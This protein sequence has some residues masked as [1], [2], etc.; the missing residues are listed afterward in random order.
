MKAH[1]QDTVSRPCR[2]TYTETETVTR[3][4]EETRTE[5]FTKTKTFT[6]IA[7]NEKRRA[8]EMAHGLLRGSPEQPSAPR[9]STR[10]LVDTDRLT[11]I[12]AFV[13]AVF[14]ELVCPRQM[15]KPAFATL[16]PQLIRGR[17][18]GGRVVQAANHD[19]GFVISEMNDTRA[20]LGAK[21]PAVEGGKFPRAL[22]GI[23]GPY[24]EEGEG[25]SA[26]LAAIGAVAD[27][28]SQRQAGHGVPDG[29]TEAAANSLK[30]AHRPTSHADGSNAFTFDM[31]CIT[32][33]VRPTLP[34]VPSRLWRIAERRPW[35]TGPAQFRQRGTPRRY[36]S[37]IARVISA[38]GLRL[39]SAWRWPADSFLRGDIGGGDDARRRLDLQ[40][41]QLGEQAAQKFHGETPR[42]CR[43]NSDSRH[44]FRVSLIPAW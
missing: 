34:G 20:A 42:V 15:L 26:C 9:P 5:T 2:H 1:P 28:A 36:A 24:A 25:R 21:A 4:G 18:I 12:T 17:K 10:S 35:R 11:P 40:E 30:L 3:D 14:D 7:K 22:V 41:P 43:E 23:P 19:L 27:A 37:H 33:R 29:A 6:N 16:D 32:W 13:G 39:V 31:I 8:A 38:S 44:M